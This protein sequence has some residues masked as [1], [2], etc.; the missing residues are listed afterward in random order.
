MLIIINSNGAQIATLSVSPSV[1]LSVSLSVD[2]KN[3]RPWPRLLDRRG[4]GS[5]EQT[6]RQPDRQS[7]RQTDRQGRDL[8]NRQKAGKI[9]GCQHDFPG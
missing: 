4:N 5:R 8:E 1:C 9:P 2:Q 6:D 7:D 3:Q